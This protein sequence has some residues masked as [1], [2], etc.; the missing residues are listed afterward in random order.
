MFQWA[1]LVKSQ[2]GLHMEHSGS[3]LLGTS[4]SKMREKLYTDGESC[5]TTMYV[6]IACK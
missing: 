1:F 4:I 3:A 2:N 6:K 5:A